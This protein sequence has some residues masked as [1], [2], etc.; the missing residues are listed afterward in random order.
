MKHTPDPHSRHNG[1]PIRRDR[2]A[3]RV[4]SRCAKQSQFVRP[5]QAGKPEIR[6]SKPETSSNDPSGQTC[7]GPVRQTKPIGRPQPGSRRAGRTGATSWRSVPDKPNWP[8]PTAGSGA[9]DALGRRLI[10]PGAPNKPNLAR[11][12]PVRACPEPAEGA[13]GENALRRHYQRRKQSQLAWPGRRA[14]CRSSCAKQTQLGPSA[15]SP[16]RRADQ[17][18]SPCRSAPNKPN[19]APTAR[20]RRARSYRLWPGAGQ[21]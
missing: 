17:R 16:P 9:S 20:A 11:S 18:A 3:H 19:L 1:L 2:P 21:R 10:H 13:L 6:S 15:R 4:L 7:L 14:C 12:A 5:F 8:G